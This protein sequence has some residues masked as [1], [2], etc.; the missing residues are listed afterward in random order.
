M[1]RFL[2]SLPIFSRVLAPAC[3]PPAV[4][5]GSS[6]PTSSPTYVVGGVFDDG[7]SNRGEVE[8]Y[9]GSDLHFL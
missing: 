4:Y 5:E 7:Y 1:F 3:I 2:R 8:V 9:Y 6:F